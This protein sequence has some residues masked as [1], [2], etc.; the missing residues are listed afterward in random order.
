MDFALGHD[1]VLAVAVVEVIQLHPVSH[2][3]PN[4][5]LLRRGAAVCLAGG[6]SPRYDLEERPESCQG[7]REDGQTDFCDG[8]VGL[9]VSATDDIRR[10]FLQTRDYRRRNLLDESGKIRICGLHTGWLLQVPNV[11]QILQTDDSDHRAGDTQTQETDDRALNLDA[12]LDAPKEVGRERGVE[13][14]GGDVHGRDG[15]AG[16]GE[17]GGRET[18]SLAYTPGHGKRHTLEG[19]DEGHHRRP[20]GQDGDGTHQQNPHAL[21]RDGDSE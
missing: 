15:V 9:E 11:D 4:T 16:G 19:D 8:T 17:G 6:L 13:Q 3:L 18:G 7:R 20:Y 21:A 12:E 14:A 1:E 10:N 5:R 2:L